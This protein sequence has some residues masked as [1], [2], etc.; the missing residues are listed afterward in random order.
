MARCMQFDDQDRAALRTLDKDFL[1]V[2]GVTATATGEMELE[3][4]RPD[5]DQFLLTLTLPAG[6]KLDVRIRRAQLLEQLNI[7]TDKI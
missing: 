3:I 1:I 6:E 5:G 7:E 4:V 2:D